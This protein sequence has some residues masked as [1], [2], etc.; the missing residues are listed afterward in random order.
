MPMRNDRF[1]QCVT[2]AM[3]SGR[4]AHMRPVIEKELL[5]YDI[6]FCLEQQGLLQSLVF[7]GGT[8]LRLCYGGNR[9]SE[10]LDFA[11]GRDFSAAQLHE[12]QAC[13]SDYIGTRYGFEVRVKSPGPLNTTSGMAEL[14]ID[15]W[16]V[17]VI[18]APQRRDLPAQ[19]IHIEV[20]N[21]P[22]YTQRV[23]P[24]RVHYDFLPD[25]YDTIFV[26]A[27][28]LDE[29]LADKLIALP[30]TQRYV[31]YRDI[32]DL[33]WLCQQG[34]EVLPDLVQHKIRDYRLTDYAALSED[35]LTRL[36]GIV[37]SD[38][39]QAEMK[40]FLPTDVYARTFATAG[41]TDYLVA[42]VTGLFRTLQRGLSGAAPEFVL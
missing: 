21:V 10:D 36:P 5:H 25:G 11:G 35:L 8:L 38:V 41:F 26:R 34:A 16:Q 17:V 22:A 30:A 33:A 40:R 37:T 20:A 9:Y 24:L 27:E 29:V 7:Q 39:C 6:F 14:Q 2:Q 23:L 28:S 19:R 15:R 42:T 12:M 4:A 31:R 13:L 1:A 32:W 3:Q 18:T